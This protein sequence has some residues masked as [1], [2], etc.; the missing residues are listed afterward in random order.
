MQKKEWYIIE[1]IGDIDSPALIVYPGRV[2]ENILDAIKMVGNAGSL[3]PHVKTS[4]MSAVGKL[5]M[6]EGITKFKCAPIAEAEMLAMIDAKDVL[7]AY[8][9]VGPKILRLLQLIKAY[10]ST[11][12]SCL[13]DSIDNA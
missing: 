12:F 8:Q 11:A 7:L 13:V 3:R 4:K 2:K 6:N 9:P 10:P 1:N 5:L